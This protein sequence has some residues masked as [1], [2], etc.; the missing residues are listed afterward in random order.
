ME[1][2]PSVITDLQGILRLIEVVSFDSVEKPFQNFAPLN[3]KLFC[4][5]AELLKGSLKSEFVFRRLRV[6][7]TVFLVKGIWEQCCLSF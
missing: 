6:V 5:L 4:P 7:L 1:G 2:G 3:E